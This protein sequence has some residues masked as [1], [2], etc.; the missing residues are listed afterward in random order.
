MVKKSQLNYGRSIVELKKYKSCIVVNDK[1]CVPSLLCGSC[2]Y[3]HEN[4]EEVNHPTRYGGDTVYECIK[5]LKAWMSPDEYKGFLRG[6]FIKY[7]CRLGK[8]DD[9]V[10][11]LKKARFY[12]DKLIEFEEENGKDRSKE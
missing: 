2:E 10:Q 3:N 7:V 11:E 12:L 4:K 1:E 5:V 8:K 6:N 9:N